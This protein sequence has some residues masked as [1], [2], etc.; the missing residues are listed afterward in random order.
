M[1]L[2]VILRAEPFTCGRWRQIYHRHFYS[3]SRQ[4]FL[5][6]LQGNIFI[7]NVD[8]TYLNNHRTIFHWLSRFS[9]PKE[10]GD[11]FCS[12]AQ[13][14]MI[15]KSCRSTCC[16]FPTAEFSRQTRR[17]CSWDSPEFLVDGW[18]Y[19][20]TWWLICWERSSRALWTG[21]GSFEP[22]QVCL[23]SFQRW[24]ETSQNILWSSRCWKIAD[25]F[26]TC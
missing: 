22:G 1:H 6:E 14:E 7:F 10:A 3:V 2:Q 13:S 17:C 15:W 24:P 16:R 5:V 18:C 9:Q 19:Y 25:S 23:V 4:N 21:Q 26:R 20:S 11:K 12:W 8:T